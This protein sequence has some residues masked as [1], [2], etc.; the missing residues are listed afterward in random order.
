MI[1]IK[2]IFVKV[3]NIF[4]LH[5]DRKVLDQQSDNA[6]RANV[7]AQQPVTLQTVSGQYCD[8]MGKMILLDVQADEVTD[9]RINQLIRNKPRFYNLLHKVV[10]GGLYDY[11]HQ[12]SNDLYIDM[13]KLVQEA[14]YNT[15]K[16]ISSYD[17]DYRP[18]Y[19]SDTNIVVANGYQTCMYGIRL[20]YDLGRMDQYKEEEFKKFFR[21]ITATPKYKELK[22]EYQ[23][24]QLKA[25]L[26][27]AKLYIYLR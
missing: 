22:E 1:K 23:F 13:M 2:D 11:F 16:Y 18:L 26:N 17:E 25:V 9:Q 6:L 10:K 7:Q 20:I 21:K 5:M 14:A 15:N 24:M 19:T 4:S 3:I 8:C 27:E 12:I